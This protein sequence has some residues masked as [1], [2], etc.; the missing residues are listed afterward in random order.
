M[1]RQKI[2]YLT[3]ESLKTQPILRSQVIP[4]IKAIA[5]QSNYETDLVTVEES[6]DRFVRQLS[7]SVRHLPVQKKNFLRDMVAGLR[8]MLKNGKN[9]QIVH[10]R[11]YFPMFY[12]LVYRL[13]RG[14]FRLIFDMRGLMPYEFKLRARRRPV[15]M[16]YYRVM[17]FFERLFVRMAGVIVVV[18]ANFQR[19]LQSVYAV[20][21]EKVFRVSTFAV[22]RADTPAQR[23]IVFP[24]ISD[25]LIFVYSGSM[26][27]WQQFDSVCLLFLEIQKAIPRARL[28]VLTNQAD[29]AMTFLRHFGDDL[30]Q[31]RTAPY[32]EMG[33]YLQ[34]CHYGFLIR[35]NHLVNQVA[36]PIKLNDYFS[37]G[38]KVIISPNI[39]D[40]QH[41]V[42]KYGLGL[43]LNDYSHE[44]VCRFVR[45]YHEDLQ[46]NY[47]KKLIR[48]VFREQ[49]DI[50][51][52]V[53]KY[54]QIYNQLLER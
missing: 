1:T 6:P 8:F 47:D 30:F 22:M 43:I 45:A 51:I 29:E 4:L 26:E 7:S 2:L 37:A 36:A 54:I 38:L 15:Y 20:P 42:E 52:A 27:E 41:L 28:L 19:Y 11:S 50:G 25:P 53:N 34:Q 13:F 18:S 32:Q 40:S 23:K 49:F 10:V 33:G 9:Y 39:G 16:R 35:E 5:E 44:G 24:D 12:L 31:V 17:L 46:E 48:E 3:Y 14:R 21:E